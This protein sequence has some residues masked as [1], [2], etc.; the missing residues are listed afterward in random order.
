MNIIA[1]NDR[2]PEETLAQDIRALGDSVSVIYELVATDTLS[3]DQT[4]F[5]KA[6]VDHIS[7][8]LDKEHILAYT[9]NKSIFVSAVE[10]GTAKIA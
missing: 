10:A 6:N 4:R 2:T 7:L 1:P 8:M 3:S 9:G 5:L